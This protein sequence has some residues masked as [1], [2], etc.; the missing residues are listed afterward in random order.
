VTKLFYNIKLQTN[1]CGKYAFFHLFNLNLLEVLYWY[2]DE[3]ANAL[4]KVGSNLVPG[5][6]FL[7]ALKC[8]ESKKSAKDSIFEIK[9]IPKKIWLHKYIYIISAFS[10]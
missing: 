5:P 4:C 9:T 10:S 1:I 8:L 2:M 7:W 6:Q 3:N